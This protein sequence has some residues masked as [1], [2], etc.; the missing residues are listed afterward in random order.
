MQVGTS[1]DRIVIGAFRTMAHAGAI[2]TANYGFTGGGRGT[3][4]GMSVVERQ[5]DASMLLGRAKTALGADEYAWLTLTYDEGGENNYEALYVLAKGLPK[6][7]KNP[8]FVFDVLCWAVNV[9]N[10]T[11]PMIAA[12]YQRSQTTVETVARKTRAALAEIE[13]RTLLK[14]ATAMRGVQ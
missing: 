10:E 9:G 14:V 3:A 7:H 12:R 1:I 13:K 5:A 4:I 6:I 8:N 11:L 2:R